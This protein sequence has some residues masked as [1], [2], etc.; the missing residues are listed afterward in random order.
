MR[1]YPVGVR[2]GAGVGDLRAQHPRPAGRGAD[3]G[4]DAQRR[5]AVPDGVGEEFGEHEQRVP[6]GGSGRGGR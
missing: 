1:P 5:E 6:A 2:T 3:G 4:G